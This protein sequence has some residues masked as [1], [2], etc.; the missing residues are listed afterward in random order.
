ME[1]WEEHM[2]LSGGRCFEMYFTEYERTRVFRVIGSDGSVFR[3]VKDLETGEEFE[4]NRNM[5]L[6]VD[7][8]T[9]REVPCNL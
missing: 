4:F 7:Y 8:S 9:L 6:K 1:E 3:K 2:H 5:L